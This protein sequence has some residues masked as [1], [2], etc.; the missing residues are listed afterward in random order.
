MKGSSRRVVGVALLAVVTA[1]SEASR[2]Q[3]SEPARAA[4]PAV[5]AVA[6]SSAPAASPAQTPASPAQPAQPAP[7]T[8]EAPPP[9]PALPV[10]RA[11]A[12]EPAA[13]AVPLTP[14]EEAVVDAGARFRVELGRALRARLVLL[15]ARDAHVTGTS[16]R[17]TGATTVLELTPEPALRPGSK[18]LLR[19]EG[20]DGGPIRVDD[21]TTFAT[22]SVPVLVAGEP[23]PPEPV[24]KPA[25]KRRR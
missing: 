18:Y 15:D 20:V 24:T 12:L 6:A 13:A 8:P 25:R 11:E 19:V 3:A 21:G 17:E 22:L 14:G 23:P 9:L 2:D 16:T 5:T 4:E 7:A 10:T 1:C